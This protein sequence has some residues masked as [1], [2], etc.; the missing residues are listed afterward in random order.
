MANLDESQYNDF[1]A[2]INTIKFNKLDNT[3]IKKHANI[4]YS[5]LIIYLNDEKT[6]LLFKQKEG[7]FYI[8]FNSYYNID[9]EHNSFLINYEKPSTNDEL[10][11]VS[12]DFNEK[13]S[14][15]VYIEKKNLE[16][17]IV[18]INSKEK[19]TFYFNVKDNGELMITFEEI[20][21]NNNN[22]EGLSGTF[23]L[24]STGKEFSK[25]IEQIS[26]NSMK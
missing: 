9:K 11:I 5:I 1:P 4:F 23:K 18:T 2:N 15:K 14:A 25:D 6:D 22:S 10:I 24:I 13:K 16:D 26:L 8:D 3:N 12:Y 17:E 19:G 20:I 21:T 7:H